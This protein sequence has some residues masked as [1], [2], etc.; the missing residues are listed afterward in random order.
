MIIIDPST[1]SYLFEAL[2]LTG[3][4][5]GGAFAGRT[6]IAAA[7]R[8]LG[9]FPPDLYHR[10][11]LPWRGPVEQWLRFSDWMA[12]RHHGKKATAGFASLLAMLTMA[13]KPGMIYLGRNRMFGIGGLMPIGMPGRGA[14]VLYG[15]SRSGKSSHGIARAAMWPGNVLGFDIDGTLTHVLGNR[16]GSGG[17]SII[18]KGGK[19][20]CLDFNGQLRGYFETARYN[21]FHD[22]ARAVQRHPDSAVRWADQITDALIT[23]DN[24]AQPYFAQTSKAFLRALVLFVYAR[25]SNKSLVEVRDLT[26]RGLWREARPGEDPHDL[27]FFEMQETPDFGGIIARGSF[28]SMSL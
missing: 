22:M 25:R 28:F 1:A 27:L 15:Q 19:F 20:C 5:Y 14:G 23:E 9:V 24:S 26:A 16:F 17:G 2:K 4:V 18:G 11:T 12:E 10:L 13:Y 21:V 3:A 7:G 8:W 6:V